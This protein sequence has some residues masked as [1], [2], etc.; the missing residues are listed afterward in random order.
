MEKNFDGF[1]EG[2]IEETLT[3]MASTFF[4]G[5]KGLEEELELYRAHMEKLSQK[6]R[7]VLRLAG[8]LRFLLLSGRA[9]PDFYAALGVSPGPLL[10]AED[11]E[12]RACGIKK[13]FGLSTEGR[14]AKLVYEMYVLLQDAVD[15]YL[16][17]R[18]YDD[19][20]GTGK[21]LLTIHHGRMKI[22]CEVLN[23]KIEK[24][25]CMSP[26]GAMSFV[27]DLDPDTRGKERVAGATLD[28]YA[29]RLDKEMAF[30][31]LDCSSLERLALPELPEPQ[32]VKEAIK[33]FC[34]SLCARDK[35]EV[36]QILAAW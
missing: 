12:G 14:Y 25:N 26:S 28:G 17:G 33:T 4:G 22:W 15:E 31:P 19:P 21:K 30:E 7:G 34:G 35:A 16:N 6:E 9:A 10:E 1:A 32:K 5:R 29:T 27:K 18:Y 20:K 13:P 23:K 24:I 2:L 8:A 36:R 11:K 3:E